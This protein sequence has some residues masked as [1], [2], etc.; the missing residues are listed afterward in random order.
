MNADW[1]AGALRPAAR[2]ERPGVVRGAEGSGARL[3]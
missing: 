2:V 1:P 3:S